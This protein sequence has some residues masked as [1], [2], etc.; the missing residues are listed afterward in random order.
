MSER[1]RSSEN[2]PDDN[3]EQPKGI[4]LGSLLGG[5]R[6]LFSGAVQPK[7]V[8]EMPATPEQ[9]ESEFI[10]PQTDDSFRGRVMLEPDGKGG[11]RIKKEPRPVHTLENSEPALTDRE[12]RAHLILDE[13]NTRIER[14]MD[15]TEMRRAY[16]TLD[17]EIQ[18]LKLEPK[19]TSKDV[20]KELRM[21]RNAI[22]MQLGIN[23]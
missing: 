9:P 16:H 18:D 11:M 5:F 6:K 1:P 21:T 10:P 20:M 13:I 23:D 7:E 12:R 3:V 22:K 19:P 4:S 17:Q 8:T 15:E 14:G 2:G